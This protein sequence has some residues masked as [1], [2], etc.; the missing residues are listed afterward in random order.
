MPDGVDDGGAQTPSGKVQQWSSFSFYTEAHC[1][2]AP[3]YASDGSFYSPS[4]VQKKNGK[5]YLVKTGKSNV[6]DTRPVISFSMSAGEEAVLQCT[7]LDSL[8]WRCGQQSRGCVA[9]DFALTE[10]TLTEVTLP[11]TTPIAFPLRFE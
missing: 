6:G 10:F 1:S 7:T 2:G 3:I 5:T 8:S 4:V 9:A 11:F